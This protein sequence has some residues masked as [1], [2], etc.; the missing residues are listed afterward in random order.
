MFFVIIVLSIPVYLAN[1]WA[2]YEPE[3]AFLFLRRWQYKDTPEISDVRQRTP[4]EVQ[5]FSGGLR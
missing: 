1:I 4:T 2:L 3:E 5:R